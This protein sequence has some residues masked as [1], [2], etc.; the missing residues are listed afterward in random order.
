MALNIVVVPCSDVDN[1]DARGLACIVFVFI[2]MWYDA[3]GMKV[4]GH[5]KGNG[6]IH[7]IWTKT[8]I[9]SIVQCSGVGYVCVQSK[10]RLWQ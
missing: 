4:V 5:G 3:M 1:G 7:E 9:V 6:I 10:R 8:K 2:K